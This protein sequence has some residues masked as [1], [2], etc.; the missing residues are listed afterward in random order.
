MSLST[1]ISLSLGLILIYYALGLIVNATT[2]II[3]ISFDLRA[4]A[5]SEM[6]LDLMGEKSQDFMQLGLI[7]T[8]KP[9]GKRLFTRERDVAEIPKR[10]FSLSILELLQ[11]KDNQYLVTAVHLALGRILDSIA[12]D[13]ATQEKIKKLLDYDNDEDLL[14]QL[15]E[16]IRSLPDEKQVREFRAALLSSLDTLTASAEK[17]LEDNQQ[18]VTSTRAALKRTMAQF[19]LD[20]GTQQ[21][22]EGLFDLDDFEELHEQILL[23]IQSL[24]EAEKVAELRTALLNVLDLLLGSPETQ[25]ARIRAGIGQ[26]PPESK[27][28]KALENAIDF[29]VDDID[30]ARTRIEAWYDDAMKNA[31]ELF[32]RR[33][34]RWVIAISLIVTLVV[35]G[36]SFAIGRAFLVQPV[37]MSTIEDFLN[38]YPP[39]PAAPQEGDAS[40]AQIQVQTKLISDILQS[41][42]GLNLPLPWW[43]GP[44]PETAQ[45]W[46]TM[47]V[48]LM[49]T[50]LAVSQGSSF[51]YDI[52]KA[53]KP[54]NN[55]PPP[56]PKSGDQD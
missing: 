38:Q 41:L 54:G 8:L 33:V 43:R 55:P 22:I 36:D 46:A 49:F 1:V 27:A 20:E 50:W 37:E 4:K 53:I 2:Q 34:R 23:I 30:Q 32:T 19:S 14:V 13:S 40:L 56:P 12:L 3:K 42:E 29:G 6:L 17:K 9:L 48:G 25:L 18:L 52:L 35:G 16:V 31:N 45:G 28:R 7:Q 5:L 10:T 39:D 44:L 11:P 15:R 47:L 26:L 21:R 51:W 24:P